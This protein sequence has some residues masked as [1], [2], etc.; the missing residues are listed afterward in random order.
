[1]KRLNQIALAGVAL[2]GA[3]CA[4]PSGN[5]AGPTDPSLA[6]GVS[7]QFLVLGTGN[8]LP[9][10]FAAQVAALGGAVTTT[11][12]QIGV[13]SVA[14]SDPNFAAKVAKLQG[15]AA[16]GDD[17]NM[18]WVPNE[19]V[20]DA[21]EVDVSAGS[22]GFGDAETFRP[23]Q[24]A[25]DAI[26]A[27]AAW[28]AGNF[29]AGARVAILDGGIYRSHI[30]I[31]PNLDVAHSTSFV[32]GQ[33]FDSDVG[34]FWHGTHVAGI[35][36]A[37][38]NNI[39]TVGIAPSATLIGVKVLQNGSGLF[40]W[41]IQGMVYASLPIAAGGAGADIINMSLGG[42]FFRQGVDAAHL[43][44]AVSRAATFATQQGT[45]V[46]AAAGNSAIDLDH[47]ANLLFIPAQSTNVI[48][49][50]ATGPMGWATG[51]PFDLDRP[52]SYTNFGQSA[53]DL[54][55]P[56]GDFVLPGSNVCV[57]PRNPSGSV[58]NFCWVFDMVM[59]PCRGSG[60]SIST[61]CW[62]AGTSMASPHVAGVA[63]LLVGKY[64]HV[65]PARLEQLLRASADD[66]GKP[67]NDDFY[68][69]GRVN[70]ARAVQ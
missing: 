31:A 57:K 54:A 22:Q 23:I 8:T 58:V 65:G 63:A 52:A 41:I 56:G 25:P 7:Q 66:L 14:S 21:G 27:P 39:G 68:G 1:M 16:A 50:S 28:N 37:A 70:A 67:G 47:T 26:G 55:A 35:V 6:A 43:A 46:I 20:V 61:Y 2:L 29:G 12:P 24:W 11:I 60:A 38:G 4:D 9:A 69:G 36:A 59:A 44:N 48:S 5:R 10:N 32:P 45:L 62:A 3:A 19:Q 17:P 49:V 13:A 42:A 40:S 15:I 51:G 30:D 53:I 34:T 64:G 33:S 18:Q